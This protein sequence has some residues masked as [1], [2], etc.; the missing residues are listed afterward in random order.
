MADVTLPVVVDGMTYIADDDPARPMYEVLWRMRRPVAL[1]DLM[2]EPVRTGYIGDGEPLDRTGLPPSGA[3]AVPKVDVDQVYLPVRGGVARCQVYRPREADPDAL[4]PLML[5]LHGGGFTVGVSEDCDFVTRKLAE[6][7]NVVVVSANYRMAPEYPFPTPFDDVCD[8]Y[9]WLIAHGIELGGD[10]AR[11]V[12]AGDS[13][14]SNFA[15]AVPLRARDE[16]L[17]APRAVVLLGAFVDFHYE[18]WP[19]FQALAPRGIVY[20]SGFMGYI[21]GAYLPTTAW[22]HPWASPID[23]DLADYPLAVVIAGSHDPLVDSARA[24][25]ARVRAAGGRTVDYFPDGMPH[26]FYFFPGIF[27]EENVAYQTI[28]AGLADALAEP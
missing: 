20:D 27:G 28:S 18:Q 4:L 16:G 10:P 15:A 23:G 24:F 17:P 1:R 8:V 19:S 21:R 11:L 26:G 9:R 2:I 13:A 12:V 7:N 5:Y 6:T 22:D 25:S 3:E 14:G